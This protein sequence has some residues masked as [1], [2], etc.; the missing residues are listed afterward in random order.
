MN[1]LKSW[2]VV[3]GA[4]T[5][6]VGLL[7][8]VLRPYDPI[9]MFLTAGVILCMLAWILDARSKNMADQKKAARGPVPVPATKKATEAA[10]PGAGTSSQSRAAVE[11]AQELQRLAESPESN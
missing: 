6:A 1:V 10:G 7:L 2:R 8:I 3:F 9:P 4:A 11:A 5:A